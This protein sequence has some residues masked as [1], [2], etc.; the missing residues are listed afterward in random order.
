MTMAAVIIL[1]ALINLIAYAYI[2]ISWRHDCREYGR[3]N[4]AVPL[5]DRLRAGFLCFTLPCILGLLMR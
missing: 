2:I 4:I 3:D 1:A 5:R